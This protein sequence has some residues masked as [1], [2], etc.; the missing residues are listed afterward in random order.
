MISLNDIWIAAHTIET[1]LN[2]IIYDEH[3]KHV[4]GLRV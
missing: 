3:F 1:G 4:N 2:L